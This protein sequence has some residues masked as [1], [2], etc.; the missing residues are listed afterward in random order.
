MKCFSALLHSLRLPSILCRFLSPK[1][2]YT[3]ASCNTVWVFHFLVFLQLKM[4]SMCYFL[5]GVLQSISFFSPWLL[6]LYRPPFFY[7]ILHIISVS[8]GWQGE[9]L[10]FQ[11]LGGG[12]NEKKKKTN[13]FDIFRVVNHIQYHLAWTTNMAITHVTVNQQ[14]KTTNARKCV[15]ETKPSTIKQITGIVR[16]LYMF[17]LNIKYLF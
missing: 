14:K 16:T 1:L 4:L 7:L 3:Y 13:T 2:T 11:R 8:T 12:L 9:Q 17:N 15:M 10:P 5:R 6:S